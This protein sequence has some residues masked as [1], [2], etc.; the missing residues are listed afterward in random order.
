MKI[1][2]LLR[3]NK[4]T[5]LCFCNENYAKPFF[6]LTS[7]TT[8][9]ISHNFQLS[10]NIRRYLEKWCFAYFDYRTALFSQCRK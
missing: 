8:N 3:M 2:A 4:N 5:S 7:K 6:N 9:A 10:N 1:R